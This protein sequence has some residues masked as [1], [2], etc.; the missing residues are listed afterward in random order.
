MAGTIDGQRCRIPE[1]TSNEVGKELLMMKNGKAAD[2]NGVVAEMIKMGGQK[3]HSAIANLFNDVLVNN[4]E[5]PEEWKHTRIKVIFKKGD[6]QL[7]SNYRP[8]SILPILYKLLSRILHQRLKKF[9]DPE[10]CIDQAGFRA[11]FSCE[12]HLL[13]LVLLYEKLTEK[14]LDLWMA[15]ID[16]EKAF[17]S[18]SHE[19]I[20]RALETQHVPLE[21]IDSLARLYTGQ[22]GQ[23]VADRTSRTFSLERARSRV[24]L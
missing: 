15:A 20:W 3:L 2:A 10:Q 1:V 23:I 19:S 22:T 5:A 14:N 21:Y 7:P 12:D 13:T 11:G 8:I 16:F 18:V 9:L 17:D 24:T 6:P 4:A